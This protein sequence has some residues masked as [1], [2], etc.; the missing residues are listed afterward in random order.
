M[1][2]IEI[3]A[4]DSSHGTPAEDGVKRT[5]GCESDSLQDKRSE[6]AFFVLEV[7][8]K[9]VSV[10][11]LVSK[12]IEARFF[13]VGWLTSPPAIFTIIY[14]DGRGHQTII[15]TFMSRSRTVQVSFKQD[16]YPI[17]SYSIH[18]SWLFESLPWMALEIPSGAP[19]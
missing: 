6:E 7:S 16:F 14:L 8:W 10:S 12:V 19:G 4:H 2:Q 5:D 3:Q 15:R 9:Y 11:E 17:N 13:P 18:A 1:R